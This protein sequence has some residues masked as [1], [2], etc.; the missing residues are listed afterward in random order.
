[1]TFFG[2]VDG[3][4]EPHISE[5]NEADFGKWVERSCDEFH[6]IITNRPYLIRYIKVYYA[7]LGCVVNVSKQVESKNL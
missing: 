6:V 1:V 7:T 4:R 2:K 5:T 3:H